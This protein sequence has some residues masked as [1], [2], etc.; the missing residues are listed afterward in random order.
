MNAG[1]VYG[2]G[3]R[4]CRWRAAQDT[5]GI[6]ADPAAHAHTH[7][8]RENKPSR[9]HHGAKNSTSQ[10]ASS[11]SI[12][13][14]S[15]VCLQGEHARA[16]QCHALCTRPGPGTVRWHHAMEARRAVT[17]KRPGIDLRPHTSFAARSTLLSSILTE[18]SS[19]SYMAPACPTQSAA[20]IAMEATLGITLSIVLK[21][22]RR[23]TNGT[24]VYLTGQNLFRRH[25]IQPLH[26]HLKTFSPANTGF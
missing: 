19:P 10:Y 11:L 4:G 12:T 17:W 16:R 2:L 14:A 26:L 18:L 25:S 21:L 22:A 8:V 1:R 7:A 15:N 13:S 5:I 23:R 20:S 3:A 24:S 6:A 9:P